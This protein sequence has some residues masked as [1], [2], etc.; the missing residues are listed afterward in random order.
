MLVIAPERSSY[1]GRLDGSRKRRP[2]GVPVISYDRL[3]NSDQIDL[4]ISHQ[5]PV[6]GRKIAEYALQKVHRKATM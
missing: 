3:I 2:K 1:T 6:I 4:Y 5:V